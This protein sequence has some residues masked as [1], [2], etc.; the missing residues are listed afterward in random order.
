MKFRIRFVNQVVGVFL[1]VALGFL[2]AILISIGSNQRWFARNYRY[3]TVLPSASGVSAGMAINFKGFQV[4]RV[5]DV[6][7]TDDSEVHV[8]FFIQD[9]FVDRVWENSVIQLV[10]SPLGIGGGLVFHQGMVQTQPIAEDSLI[11]ALNSVAGRELVRNDLVRIPEQDDTI[12]QIIEQIGPILANVED[13]SESLIVVIDVI[14]ATFAGTGEGPVQELLAQTNRLLLEAEDLIYNSARIADNV[15]AMTAEFRDPTGIV[16]RLIAPSGSLA[17]MLDDQDA[18][19]LQIEA[20]L[21]GLNRSVAE[22]QEFAEFINATSP[23][24]MTILEEGREAIGVGQDVMEGLRNNPLLRGGIPARRE[25]PTT[26]RSYRDH[27]F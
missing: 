26:I 1:I 19:F 14:T 9:T 18:L 25:Q 23:Q 5:T 3:Y 22:V 13:L 4:G 11:P 2:F 21:M 24:L 20:I 12:G 27:E 17:T 16:P 15:A 7:L 10:S 6:R 8:H